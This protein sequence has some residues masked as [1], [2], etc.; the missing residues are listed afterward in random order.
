MGRGRVLSCLNWWT[1]LHRWV[2]QTQRYTTHWQQL[3]DFKKT[4][5]LIIFLS[6]FLSLC[7]Y[8]LQ[9]EWRTLRGWTTS[10]VTY[11][12][13]TS[14]SETIWC[15]RSLTLAWLDSLRTTSTQPDKVTAWD[16]KWVCVCVWERQ[17]KRATLAQCDDLEC[18]PLPSCLYFF[19]H[20][21]S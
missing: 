18:L 17:M 1:W 4:H 13:L 11:E 2:K 9:L 7:V 6:S 21:L 15:A 3:R 16:I 20:N 5:F 8:R 19:I 10:I 14:L 12:Q